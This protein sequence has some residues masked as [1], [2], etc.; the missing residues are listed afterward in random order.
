M[1]RSVIATLTVGTLALAGCGSVS[2]SQKAATTTVPPLVVTVPPTLVPITSTLPPTTIAELAH[3]GSAISIK[4]VNGDPALVTLVAV[5]DPASGA[6]QFTTPSA[7]ARFVGVEFKIDNT[8]SSTLSDDANNDTTAIGSN[9][10]SYSASFESISGCTNFN[11]GE[12]TLPS[13]QASTG[14]V[15]F[16][17]P[18]AVKVAKVQFGLNS[19]LGGTAGQW[20][21]STSG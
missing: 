21:A 19:G 13:G 9:D 18:V 14:C 6:D 20:L 7:G 15:T 8:G 12:F 17:V 11:H 10:Q 16:E 2:V 3:I 4:S 5:T 1:R